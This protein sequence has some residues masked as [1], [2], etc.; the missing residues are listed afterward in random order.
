MAE[1]PPALDLARTVRIQVAPGLP[2]QRGGPNSFAASVATT[3]VAAYFEIT[4]HSVGMPDPQTGF[5][6][7]IYQMDRVVRDIMAPRIADAMLPPGTTPAELLRD[8]VPDLRRELEHRLIRIDWKLSPSLHLS[9]ET[10]DMSTVLL[11]QAYQFAASHRLHNPAL[12]ESENRALFGKCANPNGHGHNYRLEVTV[13][14]PLTADG[15]VF[16]ALDL[17]QL[18]HEFVVDEYD[19]TYLNLDVDD[20]RNQNPTVEN[21]TVTCYQKLEAP[22]RDRGVALKFVRLWETDKTCCTYPAS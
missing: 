17:D 18:V 9:L 20:F 16:T 8:C 5:V 15:P 10:D 3:Q 13:G 2:V 4:L 6:D 22:L 21:I 1:S 12:D 14:V 19:H 11:S 7:N